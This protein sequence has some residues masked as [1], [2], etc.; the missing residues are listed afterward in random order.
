MYDELEALYALAVE[1]SRARARARH[2]ANADAEAAAAE[3][4]L[5]AR[6]ATEPKLVTT[7][8]QLSSGTV[9]TS[10]VRPVPHTSI[11]PQTVVLVGALTNGY[12]FVCTECCCCC[13]HGYIR[14]RTEPAC[15]S[16]WQTCGARFSSSATNA[17]RLQNNS[18]FVRRPLSLS[19]TNNASARA[20]CAASVVTVWSF[21][22][23]VAGSPCYVAVTGNAE[24][25]RR[26]GGAWV[27][28]ALLLR[29]LRGWIAWPA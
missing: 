5:A 28:I 26:G 17:T 29:S 12:L 7:A 3:D 27:R 13:C 16:T 19:G 6:L 9:S 25:V 8:H 4:D 2:V 24:A 22:V 14:F 23:P 15:C 20:T 1:R 11:N 18:V 10:D 21:G